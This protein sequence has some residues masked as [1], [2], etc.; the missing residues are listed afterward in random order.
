MSLTPVAE[1]AL[2][3]W[4]PVEGDSTQWIRD[5]SGNFRDLIT[6]GSP[7]AEPFFLPREQFFGARPDAR[8]AP[9]PAAQVLDD[10]LRRVGMQSILAQ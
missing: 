4:W 3:G 6:T 1:D 9:A 8:L 10:V 7:R 2:Y 5:W